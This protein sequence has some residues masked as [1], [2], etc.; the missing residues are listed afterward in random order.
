[1]YAVQCISCILWNGLTT[2]FIYVYKKIYIFIFGT[3]LCK[4]VA[5]RNNRQEKERRV[6]GGGVI[7]IVLITPGR[8]R[9]RGGGGIVAIVLTTPGRSWEISLKSPPVL[10]RTSSALV[11]LRAKFWP[12][13]SDL[14]RPTLKLL[15]S[16]KRIY[17]SY[18][19][20]DTLLFRWL[21]PSI[22][23]YTLLLFLCQNGL[24]VFSRY[25]LR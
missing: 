5:F 10:L 16:L 2:P 11:S 14:W 21:K 13:N 4:A 3:P 6:R 9:G 20:I 25:S 18:A 1:M 12:W 15:P 24:S 8:R 23:N 17:S 22:Y 19:G 7:A